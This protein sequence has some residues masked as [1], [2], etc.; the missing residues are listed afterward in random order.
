M[1]SLFLRTLSFGPRYWI[2]SPLLQRP[3]ARCLATWYPKRQ[4]KLTTQPWTKRLSASDSSND[5][6]SGCIATPAPL[7]QF[8]NTMKKKSAIKRRCKD[9]KIVIKDKRAY[10]ICKTSPRHNQVQG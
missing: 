7:L 2:A 6:G 5:L 8:V 9:C 3:A 4:G 1:A 10:V